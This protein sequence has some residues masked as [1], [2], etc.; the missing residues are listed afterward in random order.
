MHVPGVHPLRDW[1]RLAARR[2]LPQ[3][4]PHV[5]GRRNRSGGEGGGGGERSDGGAA[6][7]FRVPRA[8]GVGYDNFYTPLH[9]FRG[10][11]TPVTDTVAPPTLTQATRRAKTCGARRARACSP[12]L[13]TIKARLR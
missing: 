5:H 3:A 4:Q 10:H 2:A 13:P 11:P 7:G 8:L 9:R 1:H 12:A 6:G